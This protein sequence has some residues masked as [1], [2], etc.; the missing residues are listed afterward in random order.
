MIQVTAQDGSAVDTRTVYLAVTAPQYRLDIQPNIAHLAQGTSVQMTVST[1][2]VGDFG[3][4]TMNLSTLFALPQ[5][6][7]V[8]FNPAVIH[9][10]ETSTMTVTASLTATLGAFYISAVSNAGNAQLSPYLAFQMTVEAAPQPRFQIELATSYFVAP[11]SGSFADH[12]TVIQENGF[13][14]PVALEP[15]SVPGMELS[16]GSSD[17]AGGQDVTF[18]SPSDLPSALVDLF[19][20]RLRAGREL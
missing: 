17:A 16:F 13:D 9:M 8:T 5:G 1:L 6:V 18:T 20:I 2:A 11:Q 15:P 14:Q 12:F 3:D 7:T 10:G 4:T 19:R